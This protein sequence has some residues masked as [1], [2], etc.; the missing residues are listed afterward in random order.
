MMPFIDAIFDITTWDASS[1]KLTIR[2]YDFAFCVLYALSIVD[3]GL[4]Y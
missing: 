4:A 2:E 1:R 3:I